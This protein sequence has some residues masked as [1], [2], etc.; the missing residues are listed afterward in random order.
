MTDNVKELLNY[1][2]NNEKDVMLFGEL[3]GVQDMKYG[4]DFGFRAFDLNIDGNYI[5]HDVKTG[6]FSKF[7]IPTV[8]VLYHGPFNLEKVK[9]YVDGPTTICSP[10]QAGRFKGREG[11]V[12][13]PVV[14]R[15]NRN[16]RVIFK[17]ISFDYLNRKGGSEDH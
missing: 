5:D 4:V 16:S 11:I 9:E 12:I 10:E 13:T 3:I 1:C 15:K 6:L 7:N 2:S 17:S 14:E 8:P